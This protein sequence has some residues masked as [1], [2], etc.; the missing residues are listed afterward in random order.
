MLPKPYKWIKLF[1]CILLISVIQA[2]SAQAGDTTSEKAGTYLEI[3][4][5]TDHTAIGVGLGAFNYNYRYLST[6]LAIY[7]MG[8]E[9]ID[10]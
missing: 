5:Q 3:G 7:V 10:L 1:V 9:S 2:F 8:S 4:G 6:R